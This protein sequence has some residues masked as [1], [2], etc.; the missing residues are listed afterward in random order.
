MIDAQSFL[1]LL[2]TRKGKEANGEIT[3]V[4]R[5]ADFLLWPEERA[6][7]LLDLAARGKPLLFAGPPGTG[8]TYPSYAYEDFIEG[9]RPRIGE[10]GGCATRSSLVS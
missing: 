2:G 9:I 1:Y 10:G 7:Y 6:A 5:L 4:K 8:K 3:Q